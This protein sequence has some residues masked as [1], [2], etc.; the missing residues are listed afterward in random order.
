MENWKLVAKGTFSLV[1]WPESTLQ[2]PCACWIFFNQMTFKLK[3]IS[4]F[5]P[6][7]AVSSYLSILLN[8]VSRGESYA[9]HCLAI[10]EN[11]LQEYWLI[12]AQ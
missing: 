8:K 6:Q 3:E 7:D 9:P 10:K 11:G 2:T 12:Y 4:N 1:M 5:I